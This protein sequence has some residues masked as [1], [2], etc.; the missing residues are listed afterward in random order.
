MAKG[1][2]KLPALSGISQS[3]HMIVSNSEHNPM[4]IREKNKEI[5]KGVN[6]NT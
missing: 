2:L 5:H 4:H 6:K 1:F 3:V